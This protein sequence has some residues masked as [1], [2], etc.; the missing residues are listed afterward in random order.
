MTKPWGRAVRA[1]ALARDPAPV[2]ALP[3]TNRV[4]GR[5]GHRWSYGKTHKRCTRPYCEVS[6]PYVPNPHGGRKLP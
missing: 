6:L 1:N 5:L 4:C 3:K 2:E